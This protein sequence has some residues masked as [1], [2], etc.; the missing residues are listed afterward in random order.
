MNGTVASLTQSRLSVD[1]DI[2]TNKNPEEWVRI[3][4]MTATRN[5][6]LGSA[7]MHRWILMKETGQGLF[8]LV[9]PK[10]VLLQIQFLFLHTCF[11]HALTGTPHLKIYTSLWRSYRFCWNGVNKVIEAQSIRRPSEGCECENPGSK[12]K[13]SNAI[14]SKI[15]PYW[16]SCVPS[17]MTVLTRIFKDCT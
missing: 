2:S 4:A 16:Y 17:Y 1:L 12:R 13:Q 6:T 15:P 9:Y 5:A 14:S 7:D 11:L 8:R 3:R 10:S